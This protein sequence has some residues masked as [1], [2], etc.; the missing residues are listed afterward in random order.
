MALPIVNSAKYLVTI[1]ST[2]AEVEYRPYT[3]K[4]EKILMIAL[5]SKDQKQ[6]LRAL[7]DVIQE[8]I[9]QEVN[10]ND[11]TLFDFELLFLALRSKSVGEVV[12]LQ[13][14]CLDEECNGVQSVSVNLE[15]IKLSDMPESK[16]ILIDNNI[17]VIFKFPSVNMI[18][19]FEDK[20]EIDNAFDL[21]IN[22]IEQIF[23]EE[24]V[25]DAKDETK[26]TLTGFIES[27]S[28]TQ[29]NKISE[30]FQN[31]PTLTHSVEWKCATCGKE[32][33]LELKG[34]QSFFT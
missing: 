29:F 14:K 24:N 30:F 7:K 16:T 33:D 21:I 25:Y 34:L 20:N 2:G 13:L 17:G 9:T 26:E 19:E 3:V 10:V 12:D 31:I 4:E 27:L 28:S 6:I 8:C 11:L 15:E 18:Q 1:P 32:N 22:C 23:D 5:E